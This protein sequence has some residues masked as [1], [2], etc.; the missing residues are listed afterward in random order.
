MAARDMWKMLHLLHIYGPTLTRST[1]RK[2]GI[3]CDPDTIGPLVDGG[4]VESVPENV[5][6]HKAR[7]YRLTKAARVMVQICVVANRGAVWEDM[8]VDEPSVFVV[9][10]FSEGWSSNV[11]TQMIRPAVSAAKLKCI[12]GD[13]IVRTG[14][15]TANILKALFSVGVVVADVSVPNANVF[16]E[17]GLCH[18]IGKDTI[19][20]KQRGTQLPADLAGAHY[21]EYDPVRLESGKRTLVKA[22]TNWSN[23]N[24]VTQVQALAK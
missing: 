22:L 13:S 9:M 6:P 24:R 1:V 21:Y 14:D 4:L 18:A 16:Y 15:L 17:I 10:P 7:E 11:Y 23:K 19:L 5:P 3:T 12:R 8:R 20:L 2:V